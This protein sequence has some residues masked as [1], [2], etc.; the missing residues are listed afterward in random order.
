VH[1][2]AVHRKNLS[3]PPLFSDS[4]SFLRHGLQEP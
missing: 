4:L 3:A 1:A 2:L